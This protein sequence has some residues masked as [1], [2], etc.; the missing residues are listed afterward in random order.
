VSETR[1]GHERGRQL[2]CGCGN[3]I[4]LSEQGAL[5]DA[6]P[7]PRPAGVVPVYR[8]PGSTAWH[9]APEDA[10][11]PEVLDSMGRRVAYELLLNPVLDV[12]EFR[13]SVL[14]LDPE[15]D[16]RKWSRTWSRYVLPLLD[17][18]VAA[19]LE[20]ESG[21]SGRTIQLTDPAAANRIVQVGIDYFRH[22]HG[23]DSRSY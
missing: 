6:G 23:D 14:H 2:Q 5:D 22:E 19:R 9:V 7:G 20:P 4:Y 12:D 13:R 18:D 15:T 3:G 11:P 17:F 16:K 8:C 21:R 1:A 10:L